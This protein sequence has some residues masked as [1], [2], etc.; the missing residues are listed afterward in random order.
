MVLH[1]PYM[2]RRMPTIAQRIKDAF[3]SHRLTS[4]DGVCAAA[5]LGACFALFMHPDIGWTGAHALNF[6]F[7][8]PLS[9]YDN[10]KKDTLGS[11]CPY[12]P[13]TYLLFALWLYPLKLFGVIT[14]ARDFPLYLSYWLKALLVFI[15]AVS[16]VIFYKIALEYSQNRQWSKAAAA[17]WLTTPLALFSVFL[18]SQYDILN[19]AL[20]LLG[21]L[22][23]LRLRLTAAAIYFGLAITFKSFPAFVFAPLLLLHE[24]RITRL[25][26]HALTF[27]APTTLIYVVYRN[28]PGFFEGV[29]NFDVPGRIYD[30]TLEV[31]GSGLYY[32]QYG[33]WHLYILLVLFTILCIVAYFSE[34]DSKSRPYVL[35]YYWLI[36]S[37]L[38]FLFVLWHPQ[39]LIFVVP[40]I[41]IT[42]VLDR[43]TEKFFVLDLLGMFLFVATTSLTFDGLEAV[44]F[45]GHALGLKINNS[46]LVS[47]LFLWF[48][49]HSRNVFLSAFVA[50]LAS[51]LILKRG[52]LFSRD[53]S[54]RSI[55][56]PSYCNVRNRL[57]IGLLIFLIPVSFSV[58]KATTSRELL[59]ETFLD[60]PQG[61]LSSA[62]FVGD[63]ASVGSAVNNVSLLLLPLRKLRADELSVEITETNG[64][65]L[66]WSRKSVATT[67]EVS[68]L[69][70]SFTPI[71][72]S[73][74]AHY[75]VRVI[76]SEG[77]AG[78]AFA[79]A[80]YRIGLLE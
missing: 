58:Y 37:I 72:V 17:I 53:A 52:M 50:Y 68:W 44:M 51:Q 12:A 48:G 31:S 35:A 2:D 21:I 42:S 16:G 5:F 4:V 79:I 24:K 43:N 67:K 34:V 59:T 22:M 25:C 28:S 64:N 56:T 13:T 27:L 6:I 26:L 11:P 40:A 15:Y 47:R 61:L 38:P 46:F 70:Y 23:F 39:W 57:Y 80:E 71:P 45:Q 14:S 55:T 32:Y 73:R 76:S 49:D 19:V 9:F 20:M 3:P 1:F 30:A 8:S 54:W 18:F 62:D 7:G 69:S 66:F 60:P 41:A 36:G 78:D 63:F 10:C 65:V 29:M 75:K 74:N 33:Y 77:V